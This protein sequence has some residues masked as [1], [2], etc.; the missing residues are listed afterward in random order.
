MARIT[1]YASQKTVTGSEKLLGTV[2]GTTK[3]FAL[4]DIQSF[5]S[6]NL[7]VTTTFTGIIKPNADDSIDIGTSALQWK[8]IQVN[9]EQIPLFDLTRVNAVLKTPQSRRRVPIVK[10]LKIELDKYRE[11]LTNK[12]LEDDMLVFDRCNMTFDSDN[13]VSTSISKK[14]IRSYKSLQDEDYDRLTNHGLRKT[15]RNKCRDVGMNDSEALYVGGWEQKGMDTTYLDQPQSFRN[16]Y[17]KLN[18][19]NFGFILG[20]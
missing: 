19:I 6:T 14:L 16:I 10:V 1:T 17:E 9:D 20:G 8:D 12:E 13:K 5:L 3:L 7:A 15:F 4:S 18:Q 2:G 11:T